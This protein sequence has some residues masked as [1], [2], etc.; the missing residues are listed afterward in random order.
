MLL[1]DPGHLMHTALVAGWAASMLLYELIIFDA[2]DPVYNPMWRQGCYVLP[3][4]NRLGLVS[5][6]LGWATGMSSEISNY[7]TYETVVFSHILL[8]GAC[9][10][11]SFWHWAYWDLDLFLKKT[12]ELV[13]D[14]IRIFGIHLTL[15]SLVCFAYGLF[16]L[17]GLFGPGMWTSDSLGLLGS[18][19]FVKPVYGLLSLGPFSYG[20]IP[21]HHIICWTF[22]FN[23]R[24]LAYWYTSI[25]SYLQ[26]FKNG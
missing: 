17:T 2:G 18:P 1:N 16:H 20:V 15:A 11:A 24:S 8:S 14:L 5:S 6:S 21:S 19:R 22:R 10:L 9:I 13:Y 3:F 4:V 25:S 26:K 23:N 12:R 7:W